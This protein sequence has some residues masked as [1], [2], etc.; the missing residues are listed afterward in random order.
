MKPLVL[1]TGKERGLTLLELL[2]VVAILAI[3]AGVAV[4]TYRNYISTSKKAAFISKHSAVAKRICL[5]LEQY[6]AD[7]GNYG[8]DGTYT[9]NW[10]SGGSINTDTITTWLYTLSRDELQKYVDI[11]LTISNNGTTFSFIL[12]PTPNS[13]LSNLNS[14]TVTRLD[15]SQV[16]Y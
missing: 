10:T 16:M 15:C 13:P 5:A 8:T 1:A 6:F 4:L 3:L 14:V 7:N 12:S 11:S 2:I 9:V